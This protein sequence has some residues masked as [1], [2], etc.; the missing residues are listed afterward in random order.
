MLRAAPK[1][2][3]GGQVGSLS[4]ELPQQ[5]GPAPAER[6]LAQQGRVE[7]RGS[8]DRAEKFLTGCSGRDYFVASNL[9][10]PHQMGQS[11]LVAGGQQNTHDR[12]S[13]P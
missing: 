5:L 6:D 3:D 11:V 12:L 9:Q 10:H 7:P 2:D 8:L 4:A 1:Q 13:F